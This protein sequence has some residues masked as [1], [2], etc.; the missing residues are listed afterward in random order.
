MADT[1]KGLSNDII[2][3]GHKNAD[4]DSMCS[5]LSLAYSLRKLKKN[6]KVF[7][8]KDSITKIAYFNLNDLLCDSFESSNYTFIA[9]DLNRI[10]RLPNDI[11]KYCM[12]KAPII[13]KIYKEIGL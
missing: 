5:S 2:I 8:E 12:Y 1:L 3:S 6:A 13:E 11:E 9:L 10:S 7:I 4:F